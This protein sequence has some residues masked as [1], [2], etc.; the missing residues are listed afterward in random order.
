MAKSGYDLQFEPYEHTDPVSGVRKT[1]I[2]KK[3]SHQ[4][5]QKLKNFQKCV[6]QKMEGKNFRSGDAKADSQAVRSAFTQ[7]AKACSGR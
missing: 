4:S 1:F 2:R 7:A 3:H 6:R 5:S